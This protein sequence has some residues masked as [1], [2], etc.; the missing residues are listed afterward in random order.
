[1]AT[2]KL[3]PREKAALA[4]QSMT[5]APAALGAPADV[6]RTSSIAIGLGM[7]GQGGQ[8]I[9]VKK[10]LADV[11]QALSAEREFLRDSLP[12]KKLDPKSIRPSKWANRHD[13]S[14]KAK[15]FD[16]LKKEIESE[17]G[18]VQAIKVRPVI[19]SSP[20]EYEI[21]YGHR[22]HRACLELGIC[23]LAVIESIS[24]QALF[25]EMDR[26]NR[27]RADLRPYE[28]GLMYK[29]AL[30]EGLFPSQRK[31]A[32]AAGVDLGNLGKAVSLARLPEAVLNAFPSPLDIQLG[33]STKLNQLLD[34]SADVLLSRAKEVKT[35]SSL[36]AKEV[37]EYL[38]RGGVVSNNPL[39]AV[40]KGTAGQEAVI[41]F[42]PLK[43]RFAVQIS[44]V[45]KSR[46]TELEAVVKAFLAK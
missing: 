24:E 2:G 28:Q 4:T 38:E 29:R 7:A 20:V 36:T 44:G 41:K 37:M 32:E 22:R 43:N 9:E 40:V 1:M 45:D 12:A 46:A 3:T 25:L 8:L 27:S 18:N 17:G 39:K 19:G 30:D 10:E 15:A 6:T 26:E 16:D 13:D 31:L 23:V 11:K 21:V 42:D 14:F 35:L 33:W 34:S 5:S